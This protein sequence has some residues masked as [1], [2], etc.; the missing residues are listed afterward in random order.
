MTPQIAKVIRNGKTTSINAEEVVK[1]DLIVLEAGNFVPADCRI[2]ESHNLKIEESSLTGE[3]EPSEKNSEVI[4]KSDIALGDI[5]NMAFMSTVIINGHGKAV[6][7]DIGMSTKV[8][9]IA[10]MII[11]DES[12]ETPLQKKLGDYKTH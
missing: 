5:K 6:V 7:T 11:K 1:G 2:I 8:G 9:Q 10:D 3:T 4:R 12:P